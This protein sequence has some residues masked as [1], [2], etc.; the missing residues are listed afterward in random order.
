LPRRARALEHNSR[1][2]GGGRQAIPVHVLGLHLVSNPIAFPSAERSPV[3]RRRLSTEARAGVRTC[4]TPTVRTSAPIWASAVSS[5]ATQS[6]VPST[7]VLCQCATGCEDVARSW[8]FAPDGR[9]VA[10][11]YNGKAPIPETAKV[12]KHLSSLVRPTMA[13]TAQVNAWTAVESNGSILVWHDVDA[14]EPT[15]RVP[16][17][18][19]AS[20]DMVSAQARTCPADAS[21]KSSLG[22]QRCGSRRGRRAVVLRR[23]MRCA[24]NA[25]ALRAG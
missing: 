10:I 8:T 23:S 9:C 4:S 5:R 2:G 21:A 3:T 13:H 6:S 16:R 24:G 18:P 12:D 25:A 7:G 17:A 14:R 11:P 22:R 19:L 20:H 1:S 15:W